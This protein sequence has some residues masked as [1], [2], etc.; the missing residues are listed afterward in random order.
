MTEGAQST[1]R[2]EEDDRLFLVVLD[3]VGGGV[4]ASVAGAHYYLVGDAAVGD[5]DGA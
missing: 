5:G 1:H 4:V 2:H 3:E